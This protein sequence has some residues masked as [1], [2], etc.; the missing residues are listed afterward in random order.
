MKWIREQLAQRS[1]S[2]QRIITPVPQGA[3]AY[4]DEDGKRYINFTTNNYLS[5]AMHPEVCAEAKRA[6][7]GD[8]AGAG[9]SRLISGTS[10][11]T[12]ELERELARFKG[13]KDALVFSSGYAAALAAITTLADRDDGIVLERHAHASL[14]AGTRQSRAQS[15][16]WRRETGEAGLE[17]AILHLRTKRNC[18]RVLVVADGI[19]SMDGDILRLPELLPVIQQQEAMLLIDDAHAT[20]TIGKTGAG[21]MEYWNLEPGDTIVQMGTLSKAL[22]SQGGFIA[23]STE[24]IELIRQTAAPFIYTTGPAPAAIGAAAGALR[25]LLREPERLDRLKKN[26]LI[27]REAAGLDPCPSPIVPLVVGADER[28][29]EWKD[30]FKKNGALVAA[31]RPPTVPRNTARL[32]FSVQADHRILVEGADHSPQESYLVL[33]REC[34]A[35]E[36]PDT[37]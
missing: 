11:R 22:G 4:I 29:L 23:A 10:P 36:V 15:V 20:G 16:V 37:A 5:L 27:L 2:A 24:V 25:I 12:V 19:H 26:S 31:I 6:I 3:A 35:E 8:G 17:K 21:T 30:R 18:R 34:A 13:S 14:V 9:S 32:R 1:E 28:A 7:D 33:I